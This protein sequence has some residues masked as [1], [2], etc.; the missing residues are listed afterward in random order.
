MSDLDA[1]TRQRT[2]NETNGSSGNPRTGPRARFAARSQLVAHTSWKHSLS[3]R[4]REG[5]ASENTIG[6]S[7]TTRVCMCSP[8][9][10]PIGHR[11]PSTSRRS[12]GFAGIV[13][14]RFRNASI[15][16]KGPAGSP[17]GRMAIRQ[18]VADGHELTD[19]MLSMWQPGWEP[20]FATVSDDSLRVAQPRVRRVRWRLALETDRP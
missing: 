16:G 5:R 3:L 8:G 17:S 12:S 2:A 18:V 15:P 9:P 11:T 13:V 4:N 6:H 19:L 14:S 10:G 1:P 20:R 7:S